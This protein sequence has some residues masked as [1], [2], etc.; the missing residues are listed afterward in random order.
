MKHMNE[1]NEDQIRAYIDG[2]NDCFDQFSRCLKDRKSL[3]DAVKRMK[4]YRE[5]VNGV[6][7]R[8]RE[9]ERREM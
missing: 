8:K 7:I 1:R 5:T 6:I 2:Y 3:M 9:E 4:T